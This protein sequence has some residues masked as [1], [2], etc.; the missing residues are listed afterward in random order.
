MLR[1][2]QITASAPEVN[3]SSGHTTNGN[4]SGNEP[5]IVNGRGLA[6]RPVAAR[7]AL[8]VDVATG[9]KKLALS[10]GQIAHAC[11]VTHTQLRKAIRARANGHEDIAMVVAKSGLRAIVD[12]VGIN[13]AFNLLSEIGIELQTADDD[14]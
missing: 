5:D 10:L 14:E 11:C 1:N 6:H 13:D 7:L 4:G 3:G 9:E 8:G 2:V 12:G